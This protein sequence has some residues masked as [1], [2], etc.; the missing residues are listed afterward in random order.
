M[1]ICSECSIPC[2]LTHALATCKADNEEEPDSFIFLTPHEDN[3]LLHYHSTEVESDS[4]MDENTLLHAGAPQGLFANLYTRTALT[5]GYIH[6]FFYCYRY[7]TSPLQ[8]FTFLRQT[9]TTSHK[10]QPSH[11]A[12]IIAKRTLLLL[13]WWLNDYY[14]IDFKA[15]TTLKRLTEEFIM[16]L[17]V[18]DETAEMVRTAWTFHTAK[19]PDV[20]RKLMA[21]D[22]LV[23]HVLST[24]NKSKRM[25]CSDHDVHQI[26][27][28]LAA[29]MIRERAGSCLTIPSKPAEEPE[30][31]PGTFCLNDHTAEEL[32]EQLTLME[33]NLFQDVHPV[34]FLNSKYNGFTPSLSIPGW[35]STRSIRT[36]R[37]SASSLFVQDSNPSCS[38]IE[39]Q[40]KHSHEIAH[41]V[42]AELILAP[43][44]KVQ[45]TILEKFLM[46]AKICLDLQNFATSTAILDGLQN[47]LIRQ[48]PMWKELSPKVMGN[49]TS[50]LLMKTPGPCSVAPSDKNMMEI[51]CQ[52]QIPAILPFLLNVQQSEIGSFTLTNGMYKWAKMR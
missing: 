34:H 52:P 38:V 14:T 21:E 4:C 50:L 43:S 35:S 6:Q 51:S 28:L 48:L 7:F 49:F 20:T 11:V 24:G 16:K 36:K 27:Y 13:S 33:Q 30:E 5:S 41:W 29:N 10:F 44:T 40:V 46:I 31:E 39:I 9:Y 25:S 1:L 23:S 3:P 8:L 22:S 15:R 42:G 17:P 32:A 12:A 19:H 18:D 37:D 26:E 45:V 2:N 47:A